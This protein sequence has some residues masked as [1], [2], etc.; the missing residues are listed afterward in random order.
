MKQAAPWRGFFVG[1]SGALAGGAGGAKAEELQFV[2]HAFETVAG[3][4]LL[5]QL[6][7]QAILELDD[8]GAARAN[9]MMVMAIVTLREQFETSDAIAEIEALLAE[10]G[11]RL[12]FDPPDW[13]ALFGTRCGIRGR[14]LM[15][16]ALCCHKFSTYGLG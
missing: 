9:Q 11:Q 4:D 16:R 2:R 8:F 15:L 1:W 3:G 14:R 5:L 10:K 13:A 7:H 6:G 12:G